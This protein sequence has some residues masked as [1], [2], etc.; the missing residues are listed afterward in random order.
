[1]S[2]RNKKKAKNSMNKIKHLD[3]KYYLLF[4]SLFFPSFVWRFITNEKVKEKYLAYLF[5]IT[6]FNK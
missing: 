5:N 1:M 2:I 3:Y 6:S 4:I